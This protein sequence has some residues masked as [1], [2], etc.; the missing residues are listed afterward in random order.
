MTGM[1]LIEHDQGAKR[2]QTAT[3]ESYHP[4]CVK[5]DLVCVKRDLVCVKEG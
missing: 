4:V 1:E 5:R 2:N 3:I